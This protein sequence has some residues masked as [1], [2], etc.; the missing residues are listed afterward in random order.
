MSHGP[1]V[2]FEAGEKGGKKFTPTFFIRIRF[3]FA[4]LGVRK[5]KKSLFKDWF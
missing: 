1:R 5:N 2:Q 4:A 3:W